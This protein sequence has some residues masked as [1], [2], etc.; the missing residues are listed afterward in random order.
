M[1]TE[2]GRER[3]SKKGFACEFGADLRAIKRQ[4]VSWLGHMVS[5]TTAQLCK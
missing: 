2:G 1:A 4:T 3:E 5:V